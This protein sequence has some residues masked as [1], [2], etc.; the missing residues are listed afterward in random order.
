MFNTKCGCPYCKGLPVPD[1]RSG[2]KA[3]RNKKGF[4][5]GSTRSATKGGRGKSHRRLESD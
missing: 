5:Y 2:W 4:T 3:K 1:S